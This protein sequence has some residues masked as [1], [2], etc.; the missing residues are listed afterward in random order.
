LLSLP[1]A[2]HPDYVGIGQSYAIVSFY[3]Q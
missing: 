3:S 1:A 2:S